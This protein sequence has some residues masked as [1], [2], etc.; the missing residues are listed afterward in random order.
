[1]RE[2]QGEAHPHGTFYDRS[3]TRLLVPD[4]GCD[5]IFVYSVDSSGKLA[6][7]S[8]CKLDAGSGPRHLIF[9][10][11][12]SICWIVTELSC[13]I[14]ACSFD[15]EHGLRVLSTVS[16]RD[17]S[18][19][20]P[21]HPAAIRTVRIRESNFVFISN[22]SFGTDSLISFFHVADDASLRFSHSIASPKFPR[23]A[24]VVGEWLLIAGQ[25]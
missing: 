11:S 7:H 15:V 5:T 17:P 22:R 20:S 23:D 19:H 18:F 14:V 16:A 21:L 25:G 24:I 10:E 3:G 6:K 12:G 8:A 4:L 13:E 9:S 2:R 1:V